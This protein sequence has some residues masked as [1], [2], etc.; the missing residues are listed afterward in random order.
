MGSWSPKVRLAASGGVGLTAFVA[1]I[2]YAPMKSGLLTGKMTRERMQ[3]LPEDDWRRR[4]GFFNEPMLTR[5]LALVDMMRDIG[6]RYGRTP[7]EV[8]IAWTLR[9]PEVT[10]AIVGLVIAHPG[11]A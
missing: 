6:T 4:S 10:G 9:R 1:N 5:N 11:C 2:V 8:A 7:A 3:N